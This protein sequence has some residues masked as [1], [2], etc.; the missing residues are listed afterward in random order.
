M[1]RKSEDSN[2]KVKAKLLKASFLI[3]EANTIANSSLEGIN[4]H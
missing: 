1:S 3:L 4:G 2:K